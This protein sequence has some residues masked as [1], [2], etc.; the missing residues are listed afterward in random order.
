MIE[1][2]TADTPNGKKI[3]IMLEEIG[4]QYKVTKIDGRCRREE[5]RRRRT[6]TEEWA[7]YNAILVKK[8]QKSTPKTH[9]KTHKSRFLSLTSLAA[10]E[11][12]PDPL[13]C[14]PRAPLAFRQAPRLLAASA[15][16]F[17]ENC[18]LQ[19]TPAALRRASIRTS[20]RASVPS[21]M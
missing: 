5:S 21:F 14:H 3:S 8:G 18:S 11:K 7:D 1:L 17:E 15:H 20:W 16:F 2:Y 9:P 13:H 6:R 4:Y 12:Q 19:M 10:N